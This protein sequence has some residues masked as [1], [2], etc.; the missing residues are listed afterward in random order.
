M[1]VRVCYVSSSVVVFTTYVV[2]SIVL[3]RAYENI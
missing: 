2:L 3:S 1:Y